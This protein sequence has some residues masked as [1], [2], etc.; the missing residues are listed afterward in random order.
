MSSVVMGDPIEREK[1]TSFACQSRFPL[2][3][4]PSMPPP[5]VLTTSCSGPSFG[6]QTW[7]VDMAAFLELSRPSFHFCLPVLRSYAYS[8]LPGASWSSLMTTRS[9]T[10]IGDEPLPCADL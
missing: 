2:R 6:F 1:K 9:P 7:G 10:T 8:A 5:Q 3:S 4:T